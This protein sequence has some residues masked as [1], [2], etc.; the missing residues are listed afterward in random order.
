MLVDEIFVCIMIDNYL[1]PM[2]DIEISIEEVQKLIFFFQQFNKESKYRF[3]II[4]N[5]PRSEEV[6]LLLNDMKQKNMIKIFENGENFIIEFIGD[7]VLRGYD[8]LKNC[9]EDT[10]NIF[11]KV[12]NLMFG[13]ETPYGLRL[14]SAVYMLKYIKNK[15]I[16]YICSV[17]KFAR[18]QVQ[19]AI[20][21]LNKFF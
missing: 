11:K 6:D 14:L 18:Q 7:V 3:Q 13:F 17:T 5:F 9:D 20:A 16:D 12:E 10:K 2:L 15:D 21:H 4:N 8:E 1:A 19:I